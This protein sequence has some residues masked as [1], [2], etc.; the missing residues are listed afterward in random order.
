MGKQ[1]LR[2]TLVLPWIGL[3]LL[4][5]STGAQAAKKV[6]A[7]VNGADI[8]NDALLAGINQKLPLIS[9][10]KS[11]SE[12]KYKEIRRQVLNQLI[13]EELLYQEAKRQKFKADKT[14][15]NR[16]IAYMKK[17]Y[18]T[19][20]TFREQLAKTGLSYRQW[21]AKL[22]RR[23]LINQVRQRE[24]VD[25]V[26]IT[27]RDVRRYYRKNKKKFI[28]PQRL[29]ILHILISVEPGAMEVGWKAGLKKAQM[30]YKNIMAGED[31]SKAAKEYSA[32][33][34]S[35][36][37]GGDIGWVHLGQLLPELDQVARRMKIG[38]VS[39]PIRTI[40]GYHIIKLVD[41]KPR[42]QLSFSEIDIKE[43]KEKLRRKRI[44]ERRNELL[45]KLRAQAKIRIMNP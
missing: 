33:S 14:E 1:K 4:I 41:H 34:T 9:I 44:E 7:T 38:E 13:D 36:A 15:L 17:A 8:T 32:D 26:T 37:R 43:L 28:V 22:K 27:D 39:H 21:I 30:V 18:P 19:K 35:R 11:V 45:T 16:H 5:L 42:K 25:K 3:F 2:F 12:Q 23:L 29:K 24:I 6:V 20:K 40:Y 31:F 10:H